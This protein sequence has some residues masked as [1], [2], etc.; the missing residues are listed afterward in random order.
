MA[1]TTSEIWYDSEEATHQ[2]RHDAA[3]GHKH[4]VRG[5]LEAARDQRHG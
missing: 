3:D 1:S 2:T 4:A 5:P